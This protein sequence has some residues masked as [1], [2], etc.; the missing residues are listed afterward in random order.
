MKKILL[1]TY[2]YEPY[3]IVATRRP[4]TWAKHLSANFNVTVLTRSWT[5]NEKGMPDI[6][7]E[8]KDYSEE[9]INEQLEIIRVPYIKYPVVAKKGNKFTK[10][11][12]GYYNHF[13]GKFS[14]IGF[15]EENFKE[16]LLKILRQQKIDLII[17]TCNPF[18]FLDL[19]IRVFKKTQ[20]KYIIDFRDLT[21]LVLMR[22]TPTFKEKIFQF[23]ISTRLKGLIKYPSALT[24]VSDPL[25][26]I[27]VKLFSG[28]VQTIY[29]GYEE[30]VFDALPDE[31]D[32]AK[33]EITYA[34]NLSPEMNVN[35]FLKGAVLFFEK[36][37][38][39][40]VINFIGTN[41]G[42]KKKIAAFDKTLNLCFFDWLPYDQ[43]LVIC[44]RS[45]VLLYMGW[46]GY[47]GILS[48]KIFDYLGVKRPIL[49]APSDNDVIE[50]LLT[51]TQAGFVA[52]EP[53]EVAKK[54]E[55]LY[56]N[57]VKNDTVEYKGIDMKVKE[58][59]RES[60]AK[61]LEEFINTII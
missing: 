19:A 26:K 50:Q 43:T 29:N 52:N 1:V 42:Y 18:Q 7:I 9:K 54:L 46:K 58:F 41:E 30:S 35:L 40:A 2:Y 21:S 45:A 12:R 49:L 34:G 15:I 16:E 8:N 4:V 33:F 11:L 22:T 59:T 13:F 28:R 14:D 10:R 5:G 38:P 44:K 47:T 56:I 57:W 37:K 3:N 24:T 32:T 23:L 48:G 27:L 55:D 20:V 61:K 60:Q 17:Y 39:N 6:T 31:T 53:H 36:C 25:N 51:Y